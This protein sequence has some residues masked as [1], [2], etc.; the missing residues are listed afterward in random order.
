M[1]TPLIA[2][3][4]PQFKYINI[5]LASTAVSAKCVI[6]ID[7][8]QRYTLTKNSQKNVQLLILI[9]QNLHVII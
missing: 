6:K 3:R 2:L 5:P 4:S 1:A 8:T 7:G 9:Y